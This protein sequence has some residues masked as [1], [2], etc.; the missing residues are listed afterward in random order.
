[1]IVKMLTFMLPRGGEFTLPADWWDEAGMKAFERQSPLYRSSPQYW[2]VRLDCIEPPSMEQGQH[3]DHGGFSRMRMVSVLREIVS[4]SA[5]PPIQLDENPSD[6]EYAYR[7]H[8][9]A[10][11]FYAPVAIGFSQCSSG[12]I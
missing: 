2:L 9:G 5:L 7:L 10:H 12:D 4:Q 1:L 6:R 3:L 8:N 11:R